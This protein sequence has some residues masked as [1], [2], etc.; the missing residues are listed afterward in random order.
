MRDEDDLTCMSCPAKYRQMVT[1]HDYFKGDKVAPF[2]TIFI[3]GNHEASN[4]MRDLYF[5]GW[6]APNIFFMGNS[7]ILDVIIK[8]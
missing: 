2:L 8:G 1:F 6:T 7:S 4:Y 3:G 5:G